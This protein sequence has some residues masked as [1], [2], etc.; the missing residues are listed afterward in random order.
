MDYRY[1]EQLI[2]RYWEC[3]TTP[4]EEHILKSFF[5][6]QDVPEH[7]LK[8]RSMFAQFDAM[9]GEGLGSDFDERILQL[10]GIRRRR[11]HLLRPLYRA[12]AMVAIV[13]SV[14]M[15][16]Q[17]SMNAP[18]QQTQS[19][20]QLAEDPDEE[21]TRIPD[22]ASTQTSASIREGALKDSLSTQH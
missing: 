2:E 5:S 8:Y 6:G 16:A 1:I 19:E 22:A 17:H 7:L 12:A 18:M 10:T 11:R 9:A 4:L 20:S 21:F 14:G 15:A 3:E 13:L